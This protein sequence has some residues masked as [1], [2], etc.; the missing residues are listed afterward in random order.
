MLRFLH[1]ADVHLD[2]PVTAPTED[3]R[4]RLL[5]SVRDAFRRALDAAIEEEVDG[6]LIAGDLYDDARLS[7]GTERFLVGQLARLSA[8]GIPCVI[9]AGNADPSG[10]GHR[11]A[12]LAW[13]EGVRYV[14]TRTP[15]V[16]DLT[17]PDGA[18]Q[19]RVVAA[20]HV[21]PHELDDLAAAFPPAEGDL[22][23]VGVLHAHVPAATGA[24]HHGQYAATSVERL[25]SLGYAYWALGHV[26]R[27][28]RLDPQT[29]AWYA[30]TLHGHGPDEPGPRGGLLV[31][32]QSRRGGRVRAATDPRLVAPLAWLDLTLDDLAEVDNLTRL[33][34]AVRTAF[35]RA[36]G[37]DDDGAATGPRY[38]VR[39]TLRGPCPMAGLLADDERRRELRMILSGTLGAA[40][41]DLVTDDLTPPLDLDAH[42]GE[43]HLAGETLALLDRAAT[44]DDA[45]DAL[46]PDPL[47]GLPAPLRDD[48]HAR[49]AYL[50]RL[51]D[52][53]DRQAVLRLQA[54]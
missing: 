29:P 40:H 21:S 37:G 27:Q 13:P 22:P 34:R 16:I 23:H 4:D 38:L 54:E 5:A 14:G 20:G 33:Q 50:R 18:P 53:L 49:R 32:L 39:L 35:A 31:T 2:R 52:G 30:G 36:T 48:P 44:D 51:L 9:A 10:P 17:G 26:H 1:L 46:A 41:L 47:A 8:A 45:L 3:L 6:V 7:Y 42:R 15:A 43:T 19:A 28:Q 11:G 12:G 25:R 24:E